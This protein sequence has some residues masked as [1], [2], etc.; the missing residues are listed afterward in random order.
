M[1]MNEPGFER[2]KPDAAWMQS[3]GDENRDLL[4]REGAPLRSSRQIQVMALMMVSLALL[5]VAGCKTPTGSARER[6][7]ILLIVVDD[8]SWAHVGVGGHAV[9]QTPALDRLARE[10]VSFTN[11]YAPSPSCTPSRGALLSGQDI[12]RLGPGAIMH[13]TLPADIPVY[14]EVLEQAGY[15]VGYMGKGWGPGHPVPGGR[16][17]NPAGP[18]YNAPA[19]AGQ[20]RPVEVDYAGNLRRMLQRRSNGQPFCAWIGLDEAHP[21]WAVGAGEEYGIRPEDVEVPPFL[22]ATPGIRL[23]LADYHGEIARADAR[24]AEVLG[25]L[26]EAGELDRTLVVVTSDNG[27]SLP[28][29]KGN[30]YDLGTHVP[31]LVRWGEGRVTGRTVEDFVSLTDLAPTFLEAAGE[32]VPSVMTGRSLLGHL[33]TGRPLPPPRTFVVTAREAPDRMYPSRAIRT[34]EYL[35]IVNSNPHSWPQQDLDARRPRSPEDLPRGLEE[36]GPHALLLGHYDQPS[37]AAYVQLS[38]G[39]RP[40]EELYRIAA[41]PFQMT[42]LAGAAQYTAVQEHLARKLRD[43]LRETDDPRELDGAGPFAGYPRYDMAWRKEN[44]ELLLEWWRQMREHGADA[45]F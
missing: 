31:L 45:L 10:G 16:F 5:L 20:E 2:V 35:Y 22:P 43:Y 17:R 27:V 14:P 29:S 25:V 28:R 37:L 6:P 12:W 41:D 3:V 1:A 38:F 30:L 15:L 8:L 24:V 36:D 7:N 9:A 42:N 19:A 44:R 4:R 34:D 11:A 23:S 33:E 13:G 26:E 32:P 18:A 21:P 40:R 39:K